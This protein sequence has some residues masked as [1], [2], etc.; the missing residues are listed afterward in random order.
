MLVKTLDEVIGSEDDVSAEGW[1]SRRLLL[2][3]HGMGFSMHDTLIHEGASLDL[4]YKHHLEAVY[5]IEG[6]GEIELRDSGEKWPIEPGTIYALDQHDKHTLRA[7]QTMRMVC[8]FN[9]PVTGRE[10]HDEDGA[11]APPPDEG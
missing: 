7:F 1:N 3:K 6:K 5:C 8:V 4:W 2:A 9:P 10:V 11:Y